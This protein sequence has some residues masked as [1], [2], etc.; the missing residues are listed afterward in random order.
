[1][2]RYGL[3]ISKVEKP[4][5]ALFFTIGIDSKSRVN[6]KGANTTGGYKSGSI[7]RYRVCVL[8]PRL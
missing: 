8:E 6:K 3:C 1:M 5:F 2:G 4:I 7:L